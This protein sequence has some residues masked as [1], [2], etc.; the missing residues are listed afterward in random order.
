MEEIEEQ[1]KGHKSRVWIQPDKV[2]K[3]WAPIIKSESDVVYYDYQK[4]LYT[5]KSSSQ[6]CSTKI[7]D[8]PTKIKSLIC[9]RR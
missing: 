3:I 2:I 9:C 6:Y 7:T 4:S 8:T 1:E 5:K